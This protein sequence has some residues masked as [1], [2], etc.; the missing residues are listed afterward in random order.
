MGYSERALKEAKAIQK[1]AERRGEP[2][3]G[4]DLVKLRRVAGMAEKNRSRINGDYY[5]ESIG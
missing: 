2:I 4:R 1:K 3:R 5:D